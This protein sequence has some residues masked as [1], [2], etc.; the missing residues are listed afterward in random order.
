MTRAASS[1]EPIPRSSDGLPFQMILSAIVR[2]VSARTGEG[3]IE[4]S[5]ASR[6]SATKNCCHWLANPSGLKTTLPMIDTPSF[7]IGTSTPTT[8]VPHAP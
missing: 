6:G 8:F 1:G 3:T 5:G 2:S 4:P 7:G